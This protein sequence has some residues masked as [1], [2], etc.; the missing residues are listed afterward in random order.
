VNSERPAT[1]VTDSATV[2]RARSTSTYFE[3]NA[4]ASPYLRPPYASRQDTSEHLA[5]TD[6]TWS[7][8]RAVS[9]PPGGNELL[10]EQFTLAGAAVRLTKKMRGICVC[11]ESVECRNVSCLSQREER[12]LACPARRKSYMTLHTLIGPVS[13]FMLVS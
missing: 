12:V 1:S 11:G 5:R 9:R 2:T 8:G 6:P 13:G 10:L 7:G 4:A 3:R